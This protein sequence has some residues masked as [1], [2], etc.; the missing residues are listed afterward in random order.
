MSKRGNV[1]ALIG[2]QFGSEGKGVVAAH[3]SHFFDAC[4]RVGGPNAGHS[5]VFDGNL[6]K[7]QA[8]PCGWVN[9]RS[10]III[11]AG[12]VVNLKLLDKELK[13][14][15]KVKPDIMDR[16]YIDDRATVLEDRHEESEGGVHGEMHKEIGSTGEGV[17]A[18]RLD[19]VRRKPGGIRQMKD[20]G[21]DVKIGGVSIGNLRTDTVRLLADLR[22]KGNRILL[23]GTQGVGLSLTHGDWPYC[24]SADT[25]AAQLAADCGVPPHH[26]DEV[27]MV[28]RSYPI[29]VAGNSGPLQG[30]RSWDDMSNMLGKGVIEHT[31]VTKKPRRIGTWDEEQVKRA[32]NANSPTGFVLTFADYLSP[33]DEG[34][35]TFGE[36]SE[37][38]KR[39]VAY[40]E[41]YYRVPVRLIG[42]GFSPTDGWTVVER[43]Q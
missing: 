43:N 19:K 28:V 6:Y 9:S 8:V 37:K 36:L 5:F 4:V 17:G 29:R 20:L 13:M 25:G 14:V 38:T 35:V 32:V 7:M 15:A 21:E 39:F 18:C 27:I 12:A 22:E 33:E 30:E 1:T 31:T 24:T 41:A 26:V 16:F 2:G 3:M 10:K 40:L 23:E 11:G 42:T 34:V